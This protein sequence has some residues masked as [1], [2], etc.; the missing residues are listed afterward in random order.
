MLKALNAM[1]DYPFFAGCRCCES[2][3]TNIRREMTTPMIPINSANKEW[4][5]LWNA[6]EFEAIGVSAVQPAEVAGGAATKTHCWAFGSCAVFAQFVAG[7][8]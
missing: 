6:S 1:G 7:L 5:T 4:P 3:R 8:G 2:R